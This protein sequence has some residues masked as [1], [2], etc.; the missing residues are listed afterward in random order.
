MA[1][2]KTTPYIKMQDIEKG[3]MEQEKLN[4]WAGY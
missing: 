2:I 3:K 1:E 4:N